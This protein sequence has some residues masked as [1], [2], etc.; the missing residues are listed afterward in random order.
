[1]KDLDLSLVFKM[2]TV[3]DLGNFY[4]A[5]KQTM[6]LQE[7]LALEKKVRSLKQEMDQL[8]SEVNKLRS[9][10]DKLLPEDQKGTLKDEDKELEVEA[11]EEAEP[12]PEDPQLERPIDVNDEVSTFIEGHP[13]ESIQERESVDNVQ[14]D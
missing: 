3:E 1:M 7:Q 13:E 5:I 12:V 9:E 4:A 8:S 6:T 2:R 10:R 14:G 11:D